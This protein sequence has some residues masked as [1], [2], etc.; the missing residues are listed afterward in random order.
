MEAMQAQ[1]NGAYITVSGIV[2]HSS[3][4]QPTTL[5]KASV[6]LQMTVFITESTYIRIAFHGWFSML[7]SLKH[8]TRPQKKQY[9]WTRWS[10]ALLY[11]SK[12]NAFS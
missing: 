7:L 2:M 5:A 12:E 3:A 6:S 11:L 9:Q 1:F 8:I 4:Y 10:S